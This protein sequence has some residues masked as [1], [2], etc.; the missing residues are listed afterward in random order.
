MA[1]KEE[2]KQK[3]KKIKDFI[4]MLCF[5]IVLFYILKEINMIEF[6]NSENSIKIEFFG[7]FYSDFGIMTQADVSLT[8]PSH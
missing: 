1:I 5:I 2:Y 8:T 6:T 4:F 3:A 7:L